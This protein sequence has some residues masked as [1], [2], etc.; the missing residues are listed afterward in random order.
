MMAMLHHWL[1]ILSADAHQAGVQVWALCSDFGPKMKIG[2]VLGTTSK[3]QKLVKNL[4]AEAIRYDL[5]GINIDFE[6]VKKDSG[7]DFI[8]FVRELGIM[9]RNNGVVLSIDNYPPAGGISA[10]Y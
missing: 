10:Y 9:C 7:E 1:P 3:R 4:I 2:K 5:D 6:N 8:Q